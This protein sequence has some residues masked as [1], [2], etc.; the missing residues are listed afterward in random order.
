MS[1]ETSIQQLK[2]L[3][4]HCQSLYQEYKHALYIKNKAIDMFINTYAEYE[5]DEPVTVID[6]NELGEVETRYNAFIRNVRLLDDYSFKY[7]F[8]VKD[9]H[10]NTINLEEAPLGYVR[11]IS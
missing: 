3:N 10:G 9:T 4:Q 2:H 5:L 6:Y 11:V 8:Y 7:S 1:K